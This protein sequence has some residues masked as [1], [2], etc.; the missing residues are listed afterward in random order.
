[1]NLGDTFLRTDSDKH[2]WIVLSDPQKDP[3]NVLLVNLTSSSRE[4]ERACVLNAGDH[5]W[6][7]KETCVNYNDYDA[8]V[9]SLAKLQ[10]AKDGGALVLQP[11]LLPAILK[12]NSGRRCQIMSSL[13]GKGRNS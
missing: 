8:V 5:P 10:M 12:K 7:K 2:L 13:T 9:T 1:M 4:R 3:D 11:P 6:I